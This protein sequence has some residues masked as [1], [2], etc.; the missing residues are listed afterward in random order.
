MFGEGGDSPLLN[1]RDTDVRI[2]GKSAVNLML[3][4][5]LT[6]QLAFYFGDAS[7]VMVIDRKKLSLYLGAWFSRLNIP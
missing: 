5:I 4:A 6:V 7:S 1:L 2:N 3:W